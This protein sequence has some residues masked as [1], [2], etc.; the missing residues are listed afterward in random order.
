M[1]TLRRAAGLSQQALAERARCSI[2]LVALFERGY[3][4]KRSATLARVLAVLAAESDSQPTDRQLSPEE[5]P[6]RWRPSGTRAS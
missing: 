6:S 2:S 3:T 4:P 5:A 1:V